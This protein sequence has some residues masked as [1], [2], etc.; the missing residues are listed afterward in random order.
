MERR[1]LAGQSPKPDLVDVP[2]SPRVA[3]TDESAMRRW[4]WI[5]YYTL[6]SIRAHAAALNRRVEVENVLL[7]TAAGKRPPLTPD[8]CRQLAYR[9]GVPDKLRSKT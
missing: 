6:R 9:L 5:W 2:R 3:W 1:G 4:F 8:E 7:M